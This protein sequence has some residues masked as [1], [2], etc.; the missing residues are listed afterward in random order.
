M[1]CVHTLGQLCL[2]KKNCILR[3]VSQESGH[4]NHTVLLSRC[5]TIFV[6]RLKVTHSCELIS[7]RSRDISRSGGVYDSG[8]KTGVLPYP[9]N[10]LELPIMK[11]IGVTQE[12]L[13]LRVTG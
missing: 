12:N 3:F 11:L 6:P 5:N 1:L 8:Y 10:V 7:S 13:H 2:S 4:D 9:S